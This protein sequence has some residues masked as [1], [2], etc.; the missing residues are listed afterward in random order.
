MPSTPGKPDED[1]ILRFTRA[2]GAG[3]KAVVA[4]FVEK[5]PA[6]VNALDVYRVTALFR[7]VQHGYEY[8]A[9]LLLEKGALPG[10]AA[11][12]QRGNSEILDAAEHGY[13]GIARLLLKYGADVNAKNV[14]GI[15]PLFM[16]AAEDHRDT[17]KLLLDA[18]APV[19]QSWEGFTPLIFAARGGATA[20]A[21]LLLERGAHVNDQNNYGQTALMLAAEKGLQDVVELLLKHGANV[22][23]KDK[24]SQTAASC[25]RNRGY[26]ALARLIA[27]GPERSMK[28]TIEAR[29]A[30]LKA[31]PNKPSLKRRGPKGP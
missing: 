18:G 1:E 28:A 16:A 11:A 24:Q 6:A 14:H 29:L 2:A 30:R 25:A 15:T 27:E 9:T 3:E 4:D 20:T 10:V 8:V 22:D 23:I 7:A 21:A 12:A 19:N 26:E 5:Y 31:Y 17:A 13:T